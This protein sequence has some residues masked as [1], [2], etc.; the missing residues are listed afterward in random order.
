MPDYLEKTVDK[1]TFRVATDRLYS[2]EGTWILW[3]QGGA[4]GRVRVGLTDFMQQRSGDVAFV[5]VKAPGTRLAAGDDLAEME[6]IKVTLS[7]PA[8]VSGTV[9]EVNEALELTPEVLNQDPHGNGWLAVIE[10]AGWDDG[11]A[12]LLDPAGYFA[13]MEHQIEQELAKP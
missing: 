12:G 8:P 10:V 3:M 9:V 5:S 2:P 11:R 13:L 6:T 4:P 1:F 7:L